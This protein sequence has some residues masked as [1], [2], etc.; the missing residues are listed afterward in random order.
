MKTPF[1]RVLRVMLFDLRS[2]TLR[3][4]SRKEQMQYMKIPFARYDA[5]CGTPGDVTFGYTG[6]D[7]FIKSLCYRISESECFGGVTEK[8]YLCFWLYCVQL[9]SEVTTRLGFTGGEQKREIL[10][11]LLHKRGGRVYTLPV[12]IDSF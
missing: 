10:K 7:D 9:E 5:N 1:A 12:P 11:H 8:S 4:Q 2:D 3:E 6:C